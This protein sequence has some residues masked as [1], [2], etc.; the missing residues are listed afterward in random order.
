[1]AYG[2]SF[3][4]F[5]HRQLA[6]QEFGQ[7]NYCWPSLNVHHTDDINMTPFMFLPPPP[8]NLACRES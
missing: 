2:I 1:M 3:S 8:R 4:I 6:Q 7:I 5:K